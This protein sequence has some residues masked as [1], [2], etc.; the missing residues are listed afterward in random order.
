VLAI[1]VKHDP[2]SI[3]SP[4][5]PKAKTEYSYEVDTIL[6]RLSGARSA[7]DVAQIVREEFSRWFDG[8]IGKPESYPAIGIEIW[9]HLQAIKPRIR[10]ASKDDSTN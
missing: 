2:Q 8:D 1:L 6:P 5:N 7:D 3:C 9:L 4:H 10:S